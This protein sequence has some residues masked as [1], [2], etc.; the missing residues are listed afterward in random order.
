[1]RL[2]PAGWRS[3]VPGTL[4]FLLSTLVAASLRVWVA[5]AAEP[6]PA[7]LHETVVAALAGELS[8]ETAYRNL[9]FLSSQH[10]MR[11]SRGYRAAAEHIAAQLRAYGLDEVRIERLPANGDIFYGT[12]RSRPA[13]DAEFAE[14]W[15][16]REVDGVWQRGERIASWDAMPMTLAQDSESGQVTADLVDVGAGTSEADY[17]GR[18]LRGKLVL[19][20]SQPGPVAALAVDKHGAAGILSYAQTQR[21]AWWK[22]DETLVRWGHLESFRA[23]PTFAFMISLQRARA[24]QARL[25]RG[26]T[27][28]FAAEVRAGRHPGFYDIV[29]ATIRGADP[30]RAAQ[31]IVFS[32]HLDHPR[33]GANDNA[34]GSVAILEVARTLAKLI[35]EGRIE[36]PQRTLRFVWP[37]EIEGTLAF[38]VAHPEFAARIL[39]AIHLDMVGG[40]P[41]TKAIFHVTRGPGSLPSFV[42]DVAEEFGA[43]VDAQSAAFAGGDDVPYPLVAPE[44]GKEALLARF[45]PFTLGSD[46]QVYAEG[47]FRIPAIYLNDWPDR[48]IHTN[49]DTPAHIDPTK[50]VRAAFIAAASGYC[51]ASLSEESE[52]ELWPVLQARSL[53]RTAATLRQVTLSD[54][55]EAGA[56]RRYR[57]WHERE[58]LDSVGRFFAPS[59]PWQQQAAAHRVALGGLLGAAGGGEG[60]GAE[61]EAARVYRRNKEPLG[62]MAVFGY[63]YFRA[64]YGEEKADRLGLLRHDGARGG[65]AE[66]AYEALNLVDGTRTVQEIHHTLT[67]LYGAIPADLVTEYLNALASIG[68]LTAGPSNAA[69]PRE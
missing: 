62:P 11:G 17:K 44:G 15:E 21:T 66:Y 46:H 57:L 56:L 34:S 1:M 61:G 48:Y 40:A 28:R 53:E 27:V 29:T 41:A 43:F 51:L 60:A 32:C 64:R 55:T 31:E 49:F 10:R 50:L 52:A 20:S 67:A 36:R 8:G 68:V 23:K 54:S 47:S 45:V 59:R 26:D 42:N 3:V 9:G 13:W 30:A 12:Q 6:P 65:G 19:T 33:P 58:L 38:L 69:N 14:L 16:L 25:A 2:A 35:Q 63:D 37:P 4:G 39:A 5:A 18:S 7:L 24:Y 22:E